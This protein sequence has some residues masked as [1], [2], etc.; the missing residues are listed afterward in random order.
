VARLAATALAAAR[1][2][3]VS[4]AV[5]GRFLRTPRPTGMHRAAR[6]LL[7]AARRRGLD[8]EV[9]V[10]PGIDDPLADR[11]VWGPPGRFGDHAWEQL[12]LP[13]ATR[14]RPLLSLLNTAPV[15]H[16]RAAVTVYDLAFAV[17][18]EWFRR[19]I[20]V[21]GAVVMAAARRAEVVLTDSH[22]VAGELRA[23][24]IAASRVRVVRLAVDDGLAPAGHAQVA[25]AAQRHGLVRPWLLVVGWSN[26]RKDV[27]TVVQA[28]AALVSRVP[29]DLV[30][31]GAD[32][33]TFRR[34]DLPRL[35]SV[36]VLGYVG[37]AELPALLTGAS[38]FLYPTLYEGFGLPPLEALACGTPAIVSDLPV[39]REAAGDAAVFVP[40]GDVGAW[41]SAM[42]QALMGRLQ[43]GPPPAWTWDD[44]AAQ[45]L[46]ALSPLL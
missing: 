14:G 4:L 5:N 29:H 23:A 12:T 13:A 45:L 19:S 31:V 22:A 15:A 25:A 18:P 41:M 3:R 35:D 21:Y 46:D 2:E 11:T 8:A 17:H 39:T 33:P 30:L 26:P 28:H 9:L 27:A 38:G 6:S 20:R 37:D 1:R 16:R 44:A 32:S 43:P 42:E 36:R 34:V 24:G 10:P 7:V 40:R